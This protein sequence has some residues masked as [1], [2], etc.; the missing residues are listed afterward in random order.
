MSNVKLGNKTLNLS[1][2]SI[3]LINSLNWDKVRIFIKN[4]VKVTNWLIANP[5]PN[6]ATSCNKDL[7]GGYG[8]LDEIGESIS[9]RLLS[10]AKKKIC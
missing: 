7:N 9:S 10:F 5:I 6:K 4:W 1:S 2:L 3:Y 8:T